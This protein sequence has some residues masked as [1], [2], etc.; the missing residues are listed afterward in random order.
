MMNNDSVTHF[1]NIQSLIQQGKTKALQVATAYSIAVYWNVGA[2]LSHRLTEKTHG[3]KIVEELATWLSRQQPNLKGFDR[4]SLYRM[5][6]FFESWQIVDWSLLPDDINSRNILIGDV[7]TIAEEKIVG[8]VTPQLPMLPNV[9][10][11]TTWTH[12]QEILRGTTS[13]EE[14]LFY[15]VLTIKDRYTVKELRRQIKS[16]LFERQM[17]AKH[18]LIV[19]EHPRKEVFAEI[20]RDRYLLEFLN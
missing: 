14:K 10:A 9:L 11:R 1:Q 16:A 20:F 12:H 5:R 2:Y 18:T 4:R 6:E 13:P 8:S 7:L 17:L 19:P 15:L 3:K